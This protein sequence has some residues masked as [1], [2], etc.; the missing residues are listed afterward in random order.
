MIEPSITAIAPSRREEF[1][2]D[3]DPR[4]GE[5]WLVGG[6]CVA[7]P[8]RHFHRPGPV[9]CKRGKI[10]DAVIEG[11][12]APPVE[13]V[14][15]KRHARRQQV[16]E[17]AAHRGQQSWAIEHPTIRDDRCAR[18][19]GIAAGIRQ[20]IEQRGRRAFGPTKPS[21]AGQP[22]SCLIRSW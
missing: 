6:D 19:R 20:A 3:S 14:H 5:A 8:A 16:L 22:T 9:Q 15:R 18:N 13:R 21:H 11:A 10:G 7:D 12:A 2:F 1:T 17:L 4:V